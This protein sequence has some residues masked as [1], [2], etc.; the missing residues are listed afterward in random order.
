MDRRPLRPDG[1]H[2]VA[3]RHRPRE[4]ACRDLGVVPRREVDLMR[5]LDKTILWYVAIVSALA[6]WRAPDNPACWWLLGAH[7]LV[8]VLILLVQRPGLGVVGRALREVYPVILL[9]LFYGE[10]DILNAGGVPIRDATVQGWEAALFGGQI[11]QTLWRDYP[12]RARLDGAPRGVL[13]L[14]PAPAPAGALLRGTEGVVF[15]APDDVPGH[16]HPALLLPR[17]PV[18]AGGGAV[19]RVRAARRL[20]PGQRPRRGWCTRRSPRAAPTAPPSRRR[21][22]RPRSRPPPAPGAA[23]RRLGM[24]MPIP[25]IL[26]TISV[27][28]C[29]MHYGVD[30]VA[31]IGGGVRGVVGRGEVQG[32]GGEAG[33]RGS[34]E[35]SRW[36]RGAS[37]VPI[38]LPLPSVPL[39]PL[40]RLLSRRP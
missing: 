32:I 11:S 36:G 30:A 12:S 2:R 15:A 40:P 7:A 14:L 33:Q 23:S 26:L 5:I 20:V 22:W 24:L 29:Q 25:T 6:L 21:T 16:L 19:L 3:P 31:G 37:T 38:V 8:V 35:G 39:T 34:G 18:L 27:V 4:G 13:E 17:L 9:I 1:R 10:I 28:Y